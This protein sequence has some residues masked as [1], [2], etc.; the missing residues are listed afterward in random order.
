M[1]EELVV[2]LSLDIEEMDVEREETQGTLG[3][4]GVVPHR[5]HTLA[6]V[7]LEEV[8]GTGKPFVSKPPSQT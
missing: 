2:G 4:E 6:F 1:E 3:I 5:V 8:M 7:Y